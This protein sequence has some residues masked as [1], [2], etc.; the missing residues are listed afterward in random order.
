[1]RKTKPTLSSMRFPSS[2]PPSSPKPSLAAC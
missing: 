2:R 1:M